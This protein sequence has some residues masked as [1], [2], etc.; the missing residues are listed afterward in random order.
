MEQETY[1]E[2]EEQINYS[3][4]NRDL[5]R[6][7][8]VRKSYS[9][10]NGGEN[11]EVLEFIGD[12]VLDFTIVKMLA[13]EYGHYTGTESDW[14]EFH[15][16][17]QEN[18]LTEIKKTLVCQETLAENIDDLGFADYL[19]MG[20]GDIQKNVEQKASVKADLFEAILGAVALDC[21]WNLKTLTNT[22]MN[23]LNPMAYLPQPDDEKN[24]VQ[25]IQDWC[26]KTYDC[27]P[28]YDFNEK[29]HF[30]SSSS[31]IRGVPT[32]SYPNEVF[33]SQSACN[34]NS[35]RI[36]CTLFLGDEKWCHEYTTSSKTNARYLICKQAYMDLE[37]QD[38]LFTIR[39]EIPK[40]SRDQAINQLE[41]LARRGYFSLPKYDFEL[42][43]NSDGAPIWNCKCSISEVDRPRG[44]NASKKA[45]AKKNAAYLML[46][47]VLKNY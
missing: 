20:K 15:S 16:L 21:N 45:D 8:F 9:Y 5:L 6:Q 22:I 1:R 30:Y 41:T 39:D 10:E 27:R 44:G 4:H 24:Y 40:P 26:M 47:Y 13:E 18:R 43:H 19:I 31:M 33:S 32:S 28:V 37:A 35:T 42:N 36:E 12:K 7:A 25:L 3:F 2:I 14:N 11:N 46:Q 38:R 17:Y 23:M 29:N 34:S